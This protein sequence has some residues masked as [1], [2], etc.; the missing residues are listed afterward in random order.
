[1]RNHRFLNEF[2]VYRLP[3]SASPIIGPGSFM[4]CPLVLFQGQSV[5]QCMWQQS[6]YQMAFEQAKAVYQQRAREGR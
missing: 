3:R 4:M 2:E 6:L 1:M 5:Q